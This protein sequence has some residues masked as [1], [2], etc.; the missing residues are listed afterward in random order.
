MAK[1]AHASKQPNKTARFKGVMAHL[2]DFLLLTLGSGV[3]A[4]AVHSLT[5]PN[6]IAPGGL[7]GLST[8]LHHLW[9]QIPIGLATLV[10]NIPLLI[11][12]FLYLG[13][14][15]VIKT[16]YCL[17]MTTLFLDWLFLPLPVVTDQMLLGAVF[18]GVCMG[19]GLAL[20]FMRNGS[21]G[22]TDIGAK[23]LLLRF[24]HLSMGKLMLTI[25]GILVIFA[26][27]V[28]GNIN[29]S[30]YA[31]IA[32]VV[33]TKTIDAILYGQT[34]S[35]QV[36]IITD[37]PA[38]VTEAILNQVDRGVTLLRGQGGYT[39]EEKEIVLCVIRRTEFYATKRL[40]QQIDPDA[41]MVVTDAGEVWGRGFDRAH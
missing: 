30:L 9:P 23:L 18:G 36:M 1:K 32:I 27:F 37:H 25:D 16:A 40:V 33:S 6:D 10:M 7:T 20:V 13:R 21:T 26:A 2:L 35:K 5:A 38:R 3:Y 8:M 41:F 39:K 28:Y 31:I 22:G 29:A 4:F 19:A 14:P 12:G 24:P 17:L 15:F 34:L 11:L